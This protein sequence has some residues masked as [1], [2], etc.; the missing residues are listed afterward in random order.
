[1]V[2]VN[3][4]LATNEEKK[5]AQSF[6]KETKDQKLYSSGKA[7]PK[8]GKALNWMNDVINEPQP[9]TLKLAPIDK[10]NVL[11]TYLKKK[12]K[13]VKNVKTALTDYCE[14]LKGQGKV[15]SCQSPNPNNPF[16]KSKYF[17]IK[18]APFVCLARVLLISSTALP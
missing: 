4:D 13:I 5:A 11:R 16:P 1:M 7:P 8:D 6:K 2:S 17:L 9:L 15:S 12:P 10:L 18:W 3:A 14:H